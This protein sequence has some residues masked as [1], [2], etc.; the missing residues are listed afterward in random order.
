MKGMSSATALWSF[1]ILEPWTK[2][3][4]CCWSW[5]KREGGK[6]PKAKSDLALTIVINPE[7]SGTR[8]P[9]HQNT[10]IK[11]NKVNQNKYGG[12]ARLFKRNVNIDIFNMADAHYF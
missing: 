1:T 7:L 9:F 10:V 8:I 11:V 2:Q 5:L 6:L 4:I 3:D 12:R